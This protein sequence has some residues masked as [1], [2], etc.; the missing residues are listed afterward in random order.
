[1]LNSELEVFLSLPELV[2]RVSKEY[3]RHTLSNYSENCQNQAKA[4]SMHWD[5]QADFH[6]GICLKS[7]CKK[8]QC[9]D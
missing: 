3:F 7:E 9:K 5:N 8:K 1:M 2:N 4:K 6:C